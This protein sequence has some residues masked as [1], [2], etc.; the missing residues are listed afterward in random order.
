[1]DS[2]IAAAAT[3]TT[4]ATAVQITRHVPFCAVDYILVYF[5]LSELL[6]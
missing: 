1:M 3:T 4:T 5:A 2:T 6:L